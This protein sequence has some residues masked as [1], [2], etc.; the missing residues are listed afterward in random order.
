MPTPDYPSHV[1][2]ERS[3][4]LPVSRGARGMKVK[5][6][7]EWLTFHQQAT[8][9]DESFGPATERCVR[10]FQ[11][12]VNLQQTGIVDAATW[13][14]LVRPLREALALPAPAAGEG[15]P[16]M[17][18]RIARQHLAQHPVEL[19]GENLGIWVRVYMGGAEGYDCKWCA[20]FVTF[21]MKQ[22]CMALGCA[23]PIAGSSSCDSLAYQADAKKLLINGS[24][25]E[26]DPGLWSSLGACQIFLVRRT[27]TDWTHAGFSFDGSGEIFTSIEGNSN[28]D[29]IG[30][31]YEVCSRTRG[32]V[33]E[34]DF[35]RFV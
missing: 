17:M 13:D 23:L 9:I 33:G 24:K 27:D 31:G 20:G 29:G 34:K 18:R 6:V 11:S 5:R 22:A 2:S 1:Q 4:A 26:A 7:Q 14:E 21:V 19:G 15:L 8:S 12:S 35:I 28:D 25:L 3:I 32:A 10:S 30:S 16:E